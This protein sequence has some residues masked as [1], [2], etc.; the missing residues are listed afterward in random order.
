MSKARYAPVSTSRDASDNESEESEDESNEVSLSPIV[1]VVG[2]HLFSTAVTVPALPSLLLDVLGDDHAAAARWS[3][4]L[5]SLRNILSLFAMP[6]LG[7]V[8]DVRGRKVRKPQRVLVLGGELARSRHFFHHHW[9]YHA[10]IFSA[11][12]F[13]ATSS[14]ISRYVPLITSR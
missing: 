14:L 6:L 4:W 5:N 3:G 13:G 12:P 11:F 1:W 9:Y 10:S 2:I 8:S 7:S